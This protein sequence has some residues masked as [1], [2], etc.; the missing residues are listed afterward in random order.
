MPTV[1]DLI[2][3]KEIAAYWETLVSERIPYVGESLFPDFRDI[4][5]AHTSSV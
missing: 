5:Q 2:N 1:F 4:H 3:S